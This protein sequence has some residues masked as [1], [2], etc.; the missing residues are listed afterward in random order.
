MP[1]SNRNIDGLNGCAALTPHQQE[2]EEG[3]GANPTPM[4]YLEEIGSATC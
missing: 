4:P 2:N 1:I 3:V